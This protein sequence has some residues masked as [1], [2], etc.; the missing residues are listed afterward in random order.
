MPSG[1]SAF[2]LILR[3]GDASAFAARLRARGV[4]LPHAEGD[5]LVFRMIVNPSLNRVDP[6]E[7][8]NDFVQ[9]L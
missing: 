7:L 1:T 5:P 3:R 2:K 9:A 4:I 6:A 8:A